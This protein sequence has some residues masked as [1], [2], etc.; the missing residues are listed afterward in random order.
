MRLRVGAAA[1]ILWHGQLGMIEGKAREASVQAD[2]IVTNGTIHT[3]DPGRPIVDTLAI[4][5]G[6]VVALGA[7][8]LDW[9]G[10]KSVRLD[11]GGRAAI[12]G[13]TDAHLH[14]VWYGLSL[15]QVDLTGVRSPAEAAERVRARAGALPAG[16]W[17]LGHGWDRNLWSPPDLP[18]RAVLDRVAP[19]RPVALRSKDG[20]VLWLN[21]QALAALGIGATTVDP[22]GGVIVREGP[23]GEPTGTLLEQA[24]DDAWA[25]IPRPGRQGLRQAVLDAGERALSLGL[26]GVH[27]CE[28]SHELAACLDLWREGALPLRV[29]A[30]LPRE[31]L[32]LA[33]GLGLQSGFGDSWLRIG[34]LKLFADGALGSHTA[35]MLAPYEGEATNRGVTVLDDEALRGIVERAARAGIAPATHAIGDR[36]NRRVLDVYAQ[37]R[38]LWAA[39]GLRPRIEHVQLLAPGDLPRLAELGVVASMQ[40]IHATSDMDMAEA[41]WGERCA[42]A[43]AWRSLLDAGTP[44]AFGS[45]CPVESLDPLAGIHAA[46][47]RQ[48]PDGTPVG[49]WRREEALTVWEA[50]RA[51]TWGAAYAAGEEGEKGSLAP[52]RVGDLVVLSDDIFRVAPEALSQ[53]RAVATVCGGRVAYTTGEV[54]VN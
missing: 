34:H 48:R 53:V 9:A 8:A 2:L 5:G 16:E 41:Y 14:L 27:N 26:T 29:Y 32:D 38:P 50:V 30:L 42:G 44:L 12:P 20:H 35:D 45:D 7:E 3:M 10:P 19:A 11:L 28:G 43:Y 4:A 13:L 22:Q 51:Y 1:S 49:G 25:G 21:S 36:A 6:R 47:T 23:G 31:G 24:A 37:T 18:G 17:L 54:Q 15:Q 39:A 33:L 46:V 52:G 40:P